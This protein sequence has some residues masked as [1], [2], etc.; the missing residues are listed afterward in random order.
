MKADKDFL[1]A[2]DLYQMRY[3]IKVKWFEAFDILRDYLINKGHAVEY[4]KDTL[5]YD[6]IDFRLVSLVEENK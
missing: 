5:M 2:L 3:K 1:V 4:K 6:G